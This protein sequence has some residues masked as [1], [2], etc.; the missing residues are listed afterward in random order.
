[1]ASVRKRLQCY[2]LSVA[3]IKKKYRV[4]GLQYNTLIAYSRSR[5]WKNEVTKVILEDPLIAPDRD[6]N[7]NNVHE[8]KKK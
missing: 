7:Y 2:E 8:K 1:M 5:E 3:K 6:I 4:S